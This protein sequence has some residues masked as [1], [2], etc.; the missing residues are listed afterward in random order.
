M[1]KILLTILLMTSPALA[2]EDYMIISD[3]PVK[4]VSVQNTDILDAKVLFTKNNKKRFVIIAPKKVGETKIY[5]YTYNNFKIVDV[6]VDDDNTYMETPEGLTSYE[7]DSPPEP[8]DVPLP[9]TDTM[10]S[11]EEEVE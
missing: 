6:Q 11:D 7:L 8:L 5:F 1:K 2:F 4:S 3:E 9:P 10:F